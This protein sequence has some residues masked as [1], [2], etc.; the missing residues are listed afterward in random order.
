MII[1]MCVTLRPARYSK[2]QTVQQVREKLAIAPKQQPNSPEAFAGNVIEFGHAVT[3][4]EL[5][6]HDGLTE[7]SIQCTDGWLKV[8]RTEAG[9]WRVLRG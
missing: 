8:Y 3:L 9:E 4:H 1:A 2:A 6:Q 5:H 7:A